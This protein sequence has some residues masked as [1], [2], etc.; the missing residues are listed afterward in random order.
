MR[1]AAAPRL[2][3]QYPNMCALGMLGNHRS[4]VIEIR[5]G[6]NAIIDV[7][8]R[9]SAK[10]RQD[11][12]PRVLAQAPRSRVG[13]ATAHVPLP[14]PRTIAVVSG[15]IRFGRPIWST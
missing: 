6:M 14:R 4:D 3:G 7:A 8:A 2:A 15:G 13:V 9:Y 12:R 11:S 10:P 1:I 5:D